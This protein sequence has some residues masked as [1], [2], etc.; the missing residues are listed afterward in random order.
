MPLLESAN[1]SPTKKN[2]MEEASGLNSPDKLLEVTNK[3][4]P[5]EVERPPLSSLETLVSEPSNGL[6]KNSSRAAVKSTLLELPWEKMVDQEVSLM[7]SSWTM[8]QLLK[9]WKWPDKKSMVELLDLIFPSQEQ[10][11]AVAVEVAEAVIEV[12]VEV[13]AEASVVVA[14]EAVEDSVVV[15][16]EEEVVVDTDNNTTFITILIKINYYRII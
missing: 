5:Q 3:T 4:P 12:V 7:L 6:L 15:E 1:K 10:E 2:L 14:V 11:E 16:A 8:L 9:V 13:E